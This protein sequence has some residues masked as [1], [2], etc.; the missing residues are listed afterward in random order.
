MPNAY[1]LHVGVNDYDVNIYPE[2]VNRLTGCINDMKAMAQMAVTMGIPRS[3]SKVLAN[4]TL[5]QLSGSFLEFSDLAKPGDFFLFTFA[6]HGIQK[7][8]PN[9]GVEPDRLNEHICLRNGV[10]VDDD[11]NYYLSLFPDK[12]EIVCLFDSCHSGSAIWMV[13]FS[14]RPAGSNVGD[15]EAVIS[16]ATPRAL[17]EWETTAVYQ[18]SQG[19]VATARTA[20]RSLPAIGLSMSA[21]G[22]GPH[23]LAYEEN[24][25]GLFTQAV[26][27]TYYQGQYRENYITFW[28][29]VRHWLNQ[30]HPGKQFP[31]YLP[32]PSIHETDNKAFITTYPA[33]S[34]SVNADS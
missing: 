15:A 13:R 17:T 22:D 26:E 27:A 14:T 2:S 8:E 29:G 20:I 32:F 24:G 16:T 9:P 3:N 31:T 21:C 34:L 1:S 5:Q 10:M 23:E 28:K 30:N 7:P 12:V 11:I 4:A 19:R 6:G 33:F 25:R 18:N